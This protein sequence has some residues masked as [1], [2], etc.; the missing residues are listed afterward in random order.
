MAISLGR[1]TQHF[2]VQTNIMIIM[3]AP[4]RIP[5][6]SGIKWGGLSSFISIHFPDIKEIVFGFR[7]VGNLDW[8]LLPA[9]LP[10]LDKRQEPCAEF[11]HCS[12]DGCAI[13]GTHME[14]LA[15]VSGAHADVCDFGIL[16]STGKVA[17]AWNSRCLWG[18][19]RKLWKF[20]VSDCRLNA[21]GHSTW[22]LLVIILLSD[23]GIRTLRILRPWAA[24]GCSEWAEALF[25]K[26]AH[27]EERGSLNGKG[28]CAWQQLAD[29]GSSWDRL[30]IPDD[31]LPPHLF[32][33]RGLEDIYET[34]MADATNISWMDGQGCHLGLDPPTNCAMAAVLGLVMRAMFVVTV[35]VR[36]G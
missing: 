5:G 23:G 22:V 21:N 30:R 19:W 8:S 27:K 12:F 20:E 14:T 13:A 32:G 31:D 29:H 18:P 28:C 1:L 36:N 26:M 7:L 4:L 16:E 25:F 3:L 11:Q 9:S 6:P 2:Q 24:H 34:N 15:F 10:H 33:C 17:G 35:V